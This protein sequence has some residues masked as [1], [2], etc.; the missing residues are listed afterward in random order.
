[1]WKLSVQ[2]EGAV[3]SIS[4]EQNCSGNFILTLRHIY[5]LVRKSNVWKPIYAHNFDRTA[6][7]KS[8]FIVVSAVWR[9]NVQY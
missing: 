5:A 3:D 4:Y 1:M 7:H 9:G 8:N 6:V 2:G